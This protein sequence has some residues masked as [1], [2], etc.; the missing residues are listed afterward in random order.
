MGYISEKTV[1][2]REELSPVEGEGEGG[3]RRD[4]GVP[5][6]ERMLTGF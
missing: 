6:P 3:R 2:G 1:P 5:W 4:P